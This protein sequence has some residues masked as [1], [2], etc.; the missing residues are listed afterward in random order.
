MIQ[1]LAPTSLLGIMGGGGGAGSMSQ[2][3]AATSLLGV[4]GGEEGEQA[5]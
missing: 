4:M 5:A 3:L 1:L 2:L